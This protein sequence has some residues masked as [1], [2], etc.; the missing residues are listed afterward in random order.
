MI[1]NLKGDKIS[2]ADCYKMKLKGLQQ[3]YSVF[4]MRKITRNFK[5]LFESSLKASWY[6]FLPKMPSVCKQNSLFCFL[7]AFLY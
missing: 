3:F 5:K 6:V 1:S 4:L 2:S 7:R